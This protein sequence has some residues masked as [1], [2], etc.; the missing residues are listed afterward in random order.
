MAL[1]Q[2]A[3]GQ[4]A[5]L[6]AP[7]RIKKLSRN[8]K[9]WTGLLILCI[10]TSFAHWLISTYEPP[11]PPRW[12][13]VKYYLYSTE[14]QLDQSNS[15]KIPSDLKSVQSALIFFKPETD[16]AKLLLPPEMVF[17]TFTLTDKDVLR[18]TINT[19]VAQ[20]LSGIDPKNRAVAE[21]ILQDPDEAVS[22]DKVLFAV[23]Q[24]NN[25]SAPEQLLNKSLQNVAREIDPEIYD[26]A[27]QHIMLA[28][29]LPPLTAS[30]AANITQ[31][32]QTIEKLGVYRILQD[33]SVSQSM[34]TTM[35][36][37][38]TDFTLINDRLVPLQNGRSAQLI[39]EPGQYLLAQDAILSPIT[40]HL[41]LHTLNGLP[42]ALRGSGHGWTSLSRLE[43]GTFYPMMTMSVFNS[44]DTD[45]QQ[46]V[47]RSE[48]TN[49]ATYTNLW[50]NHPHDWERSTLALNKVPLPD[51]PSK[52]TLSELTPA[53]VGSFIYQRQWYLPQYSTQEY[54]QNYLLQALSKSRNPKTSIA[55]VLEIIHIRIE[56]V[57]NGLFWGTL[58][59]W[60]NHT[61]QDTR[62]NLVTSNCVAYATDL[63]NTIVVTQSYNPRFL[64]LIPAP[65]EL[66]R[67]MNSD[68]VIELPGAETETK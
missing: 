29:S 44:L 31:P 12:V 26:T 58:Q 59:M 27:A 41:G 53:Q 23:T 64:G 28:P 39:L 45:N 30:A 21:R 33:A 17:N 51:G 24:S 56:N 25:I 63:W 67:K 4:P 55:L 9:F 1:S 42:Y 6:Q 50:I 40:F 7:G 46:V 43:E 68:S 54:Y 18:A 60:L 38:Y 36:E 2:T 52:T 37:N 48:V 14:T 35:Q 5:P 49:V 15:E 61:L 8:R 47:A 20:N 62:Y 13:G 19:A 66:Y 11:F 16:D 65:S 3:N 10:T 22:L 57:L 34:P 32:L